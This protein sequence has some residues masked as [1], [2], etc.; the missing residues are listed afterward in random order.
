MV[1]VGITLK[2][3]NQIKVKNDKHIQSEL[4]KII[5]LGGEGLML[6]KPESIYEGKRSK[7]LLKV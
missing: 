1:F 4:K 7:T 6:R 2:I 3:V 5:K